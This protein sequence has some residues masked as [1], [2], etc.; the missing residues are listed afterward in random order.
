MIYIFKN[1][2][3]ISILLAV[4]FVGCGYKQ[5][6]TQ[7]RDNAYI[8]FHKKSTITYTVVVNDKYKFILD[9]CKEDPNTHRCYDNT[10]DKV[11][12]VNSGNVVIQVFDEQENLVMRKEVYLGSSNTV[13]V[14]LQ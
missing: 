13:E 9:A 11:Y 1:K 8:K 3:L 7:I 6:N 10:I 4:L 12:E 5:T 14:H 2:I